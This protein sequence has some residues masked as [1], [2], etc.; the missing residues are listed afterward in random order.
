MKN[1]LKLITC[2]LLLFT[3]FVA[4]AQVLYNENFNSYALG[5]LGTDHTGTVPGKGGWL[6]QCSTVSTATVSND[7]FNITNEFAKGNV[8]TLSAGTTSPTNVSVIVKK[9]GIDSFI[10]QRA[11]GNNVIKFEIDYYTGVQQKKSGNTQQIIIGYDTTHNSFSPSRLLVH[12][13]FRSRTGEFYVGG[14]GL[15]GNLKLDK[16]ALTYMSVLPFDTWVTLIV[17]LDYNN[18]KAYF[19][20]PYFNT[21]AVADFFQASTSSNLIEDFKPTVLSMTFQSPNETITADSVN[22]YDNIKIT[23]LKSVPAYVLNTENF[24]AQKFNL[25][26]N[27]ATNIVNIT[28]TENMLVNQITVYD[29]SGKQLSTKSFNNATEI[30]LNIENLASGTYI[31]NLQTNEGTVVKKL[32]KK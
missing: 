6:T 18:K 9:I 10:N 25:Y 19:E 31:L 5:N 7:Y 24:L 1:I 13:Q 20:T 22:K 12:Y 21:I 8:L 29:T 4:K 23:A 30:Q 17:Y 11:V 3:S 27:P 26:P 14:S 32:V 16:N 2:S 15:K 28:N